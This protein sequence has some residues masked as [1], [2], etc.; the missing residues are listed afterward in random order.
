[1]KPKFRSRFPNGKRRSNE[2]HR[3]KRF[4]L[5]RCALLNEAVL[6]T[7]KTPQLT[8]RVDNNDVACSAL[9]DLHGEN[10]GRAHFAM[11]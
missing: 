5:P 8:V 3:Q 7:G 11:L 4:D 1:M 10:V 6:T 9:H 2:F